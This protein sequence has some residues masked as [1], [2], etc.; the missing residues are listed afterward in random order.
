MTE[1]REPA[2][3]RERISR[4]R[5]SVPSGVSRLPPASQNGGWNAAERLSPFGSCGRISS[6]PMA[7]TITTASTSSASHGTLRSQP[8]RRWLAVGADTGIDNAIGQVNQQVGQH[9]QDR[10]EQHAGLHDREV[11]AEHRL[12]HRAADAGPGEDRF[13]DEG[14]TK[15]GG[16]VDA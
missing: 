10:G 7:L 11:A 2:R 1:M 8:N 16:E 14:A 5:L 4:P 13:D 3:M 6:P 15:H 12:Y 9:K